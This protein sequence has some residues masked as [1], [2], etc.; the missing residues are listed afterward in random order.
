MNL[1]GGGCGEPRLCHCTPAWATRAKLRLKTKTQNKTK[2]ITVNLLNMNNGMVTIFKNS[3][4]IQT[5][6]DKC[7]GAMMS[8]F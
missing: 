8:G 1:V 5:N 3:Y 7:T 4:L 2:D 6:T